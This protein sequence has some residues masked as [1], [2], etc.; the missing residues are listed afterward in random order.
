[1]ATAALAGATGADATRR[2]GRQRPAKPGDGGCGTR[3][4]LPPNGGQRHRAAPAPAASH[5]QLWR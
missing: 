5:A 3:Q 4:G 1:M 2:S